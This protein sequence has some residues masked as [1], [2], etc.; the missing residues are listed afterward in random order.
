[1]DTIDKIKMLAAT[2]TNDMDLGRE[3]RK[4]LSEI[5]Q[6]QKERIIEMGNWHGDADEDY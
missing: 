1:M 3:V 5:K 6:T 4:L 2:H